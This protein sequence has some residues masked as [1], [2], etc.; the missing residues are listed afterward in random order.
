MLVTIASIIIL[1]IEVVFIILFFIISRKTK[2]NVSKNTVFW[3][4]PVSL[5]LIF[6]HVIGY[7]A[8]ND[9]YNVVGLIRCIVSSLKTFAFEINPL[10]IEPLLNSNT[11]FAITFLVA[12]LMAIFTV[13]ATAIGLMK[14]NILNS[15]RVRKIISK[16][17]DIVIGNNNTSL[18]YISKHKN[19]TCLWITEAIDKEKIKFLY[20]NRIT[21]IK[22]ELSKG[23]I[24]KFLKD[25]IRYNFIAF[26]TEE[27]NYQKFIDNFVQMKNDEKY[28][29]LYLEVKYNEAEVVR[30]EYLK[31]KDKNSNLFI[32][33]FSRYELMS[34]K[35]VSTLTIPSLLPDDFFNKNRT[36]KEDKEI[37]VFFYG[38]G[39]VN[40]SLFTMFCQNNQLVRMKDNQLLS[41]PIN[42]YAIDKNCDAFNSKRL[43]YI[44]KNFKNMESDLPLPEVPCNFQ[45]L[46]YDINSYEGIN[47]VKK[48][49]HKKNTFNLF[50]VSYGTDFE[51]AETALWLE[52]EFKYENTLIACRLKNNR[53]EN[54]NIIYFGNESEVISHQYIVEEE[55]QQFAKEIDSN[56]NQLY[57]MGFLEKELYWDKLN[58]IELYS[59]YYSAMNI[60]FKLNLLGLDLTKDHNVE[61][62]SE[63][64]FMKIYGEGFKN[65]NNYE[66]YFN[67][68]IRNV[69]A[70]SEKLR[71]N[72][73]YLFNGYKPMLLKDIKIQ[74][75]KIVWKN[76]NNKTH[77]CITSH[78]GLDKLHNYVLSKFDKK[79]NV[80]I[81]DVE[82]YKYDYM[83]F[84][85]PDNNLIN[86]LLKKGYKIFF[87]YN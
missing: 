49:A 24:N 27:T 43:G 4:V 32:G 44:I 66:Q 39:K 67:T 85:N 58:Q 59:N 51:N 18:E 10:Y 33:T 41:F 1:V 38:F 78:R 76:H 79:L 56:Y 28:I 69:I 62:I 86:I 65:T 87:K 5:F 35:F 83:I 68:S 74:G 29:F 19:K 81:K 20:N 82:S 60:R 37:N 11:M 36:I 8:V 46:P 54:E 80:T 21:F 40:A 2:A 14:D 12:Y 73:F 63:N 77:A 48:I 17:C 84:D 72:A 55:L 9:S 50:I 45:F 57:E 7:I 31:H 22:C 30:N 23:N 61:S 47:E 26:N 13:F 3:F 52:S 16:E 64:Q 34:R 25:K 15:I 71:W 6:L 53:I 75:K 42:Y 70:Y